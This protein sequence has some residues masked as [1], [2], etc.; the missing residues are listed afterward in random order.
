MKAYVISSEN[1]L[2][3]ANKMLYPLKNLKW[4]STKFAPNEIGFEYAINRM[5]EADII[6]VFYD[7]YINDSEHEKLQLENELNIAME[8][9]ALTKKVILPIILNNANIP[10][11]LEKYKPMYLQG[12]SPYQLLTITDA[13]PQLAK[14]K[15]TSLAKDVQKKID[16]LSIIGIYTSLLAVLL[17]CILTSLTGM[18]QEIPWTMLLILLLMATL[19]IIPLV[20]YIITGD[21]SRNKKN[22]VDQKLYSLKLKN[23]LAPPKSQNENLEFENISQVNALKLMRLNLDNINQYYLSNQKQAKTSFCWAIAFCITGFLFMIAT[24]TLF[25]ILK[26]DWIMMFISV[27]GGAIIEFISCTIFFIYKQTL[28]QL[29]YYHKTL[30][31]NERFLSCVNLTSIIDDQKMRDEVIKQLIATQKQINIIE[32]ENRNNHASRSKK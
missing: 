18:D 7:G 5:Q 3:I 19:L 25:I 28:S 4:E 8:I 13:I 20:F 12:D 30:H 14:L 10:H 6:I 23:Y 9:I 22:A 29:N 2:D 32:A 15:K 26:L 21:G 1:N 17:T 31:E 27:I 16:W 11:F 24:I